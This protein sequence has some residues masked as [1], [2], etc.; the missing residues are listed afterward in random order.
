M[1]CLGPVV[2]I[3]DLQQ[4]TEVFEKVFMCNNFCPLGIA[5]LKST[6]LLASTVL[7]STSLRTIE[8]LSHRNFIFIYDTDLNDL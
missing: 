4:N 6:T 5:R 2:K 8:M 7:N 1:I 3:Q